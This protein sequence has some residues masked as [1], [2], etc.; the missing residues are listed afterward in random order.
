M[1]LALVAYLFF[2]LQPALDR[3]F[4]LPVHHF[5]IVS[6][7]AVLAAAVA[8]AVGAVGARLRNPQVVFVVTAFTSLALVS[9]LHGLATPGLLLPPTRLPLRG[10]V[11]VLTVYL[12]GA[13][14]YRHWLSYRYAAFPFQGAVVYAAGWRWPRS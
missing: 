5:Y 8:V 9:A 6:A 2:R 14:G 10:V 4:P 12:A 11:A 13:A 1:F 3:T 7:A